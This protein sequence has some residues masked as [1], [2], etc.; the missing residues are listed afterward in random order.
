[1]KE[2]ELYECA[3]DSA[4]EMP[5]SELYPFAHEWEAAR[6]RGKWFLVAR[7]GEALLVNLKCEPQRAVELT[8]SMPGVSP[9]YHM[10]KKHWISLWPGFDL[11]EEFVRAAVHHSYGLVVNSLPRREQPIGNPGTYIDALDH[12][13]MRDSLSE[14]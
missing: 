14:E 11:S 9:G 5:G 7:V 8:A 4:L 10:N 13:M 1:M 3:I 12:L 2:R 6:V